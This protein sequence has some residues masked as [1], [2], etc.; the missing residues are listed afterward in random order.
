MKTIGIKFPFEQ[1][2]DNYFLAMSKTTNEKILSNFKFLITVKRKERIYHPEF[3][4]NIDQYLFEPM[5]EQLKNEMINELKEVTKKYF[6]DVKISSID[7]QTNNQ[8]QMIS[9]IINGLVNGE[10]FEETINF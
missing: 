4:F 10:S 8:Q 2:E 9:L 3:S 6:P 1:S 5:D 7:T